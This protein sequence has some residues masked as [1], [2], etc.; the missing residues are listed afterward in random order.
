MSLINPK[1]AYLTV[2]V[3]AM[4]Y[5]YP[6]RTSP[7]HLVYATALAVATYIGL[8][9]YDAWYDCDQKNLASK[10][11]TLYQPLKPAVNERGEYALTHLYI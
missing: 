3:V 4:Y 1:C 11:F 6:T 7:Y 10:W 2:L 9:W 8:S 5:F